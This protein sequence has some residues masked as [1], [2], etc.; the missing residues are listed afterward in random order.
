MQWTATHTGLPQ[1]LLML[2]DNADR[3]QQFTRTLR[4]VDAGL[5]LRSWPDAH[6]MIRE[7]GSLLAAA[8]L[9]SLDHDLEPEPDGADPGD[10]LAVA[11]FLVAQPIIRPVIIHSSNGERARWMAGEFENA[12]WRYWRAVPLGD[13]WVESHWR[14]VVQDILNAVR[15]EKNF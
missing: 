3:L 9:I 5:E 8:T 15:P 10:G 14:Q 13:D 7:V 1:M 4:S 6:A 2:E 12:G 11:K